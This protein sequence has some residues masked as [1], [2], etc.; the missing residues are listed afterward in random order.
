MN[1][2]H[3][4]DTQ[5]H[6]FPISMGSTALGSTLDRETSFRLL[7]AY[8]DA[9][10]NFIDTAAVYANWLPI[11]RSISEKTIGAWL[12]ERRNRAQVVLSTKGA[13][14]ELATMHISRLS[15]AEIA[16]DLEDS[17]RHLGVETIDIYWLHRDD[18]SRPVAE[19]LETLSAHA[20]AGKIAITAAPTGAPRASV[21]RRSTRVPT[22]CPASPATR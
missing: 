13:H 17:L 1:L 14:P 9:G 6:V 3:L 2:T 8:T 7:D 5:L 22:G 18:P 19:I 11:E 4:P 12:R 10:G 15:P 21:R 16:S 20:R